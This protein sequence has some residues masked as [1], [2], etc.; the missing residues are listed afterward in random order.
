MKN[1]SIKESKFSIVDSDFDSTRISE[2]VISGKITRARRKAIEH[3]VRTFNRKWEAPYGYSFNGYAYRCGCE[4]DCCG[5]LVGKGMTVE[6]RKLGN[7][8]IAVM[9]I[10]E[11]YNY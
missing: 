9:S 5:C 10:Y 8:H 7:N 6:F 4:H 11:S 3:S 1:T 2:R